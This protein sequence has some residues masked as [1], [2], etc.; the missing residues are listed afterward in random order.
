MLEKVLGEEFIKIIREELVPAFGCTEPIALA[1]AS[2]KCREALGCEPEKI[3]AK[4]SGNMIKN[5]RCVTIPGSGGLT[6]IN[7]ACILGAVAGDPSAG[8]E[9]L[10][11]VDEVGRTRTRELLERDCCSVEFLDSEI[12]LHFII[13]LSGGGHTA[14]VEVRHIHTNIVFIK[15]DNEIIFEKARELADKGYSTDRTKLSLENIKTFADEVDLALVRDIYERQIRCNMKIL[16]IR[17]TFMQVLTE[18]N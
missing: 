7:T 14:E 4:C 6:G 9:V 12:P 8:M 18:M 13:V 16:C 10:E 17:C 2:A 1:Y 3:I 11:K 5:V 15:K